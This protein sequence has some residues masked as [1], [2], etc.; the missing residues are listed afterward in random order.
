MR[1]VIINRSDARGGAAVVSRRLMHA[2]RREGVDATM[3][4]AEKLTND[5]NVH[6]AGTSA[7]IRRAFLRER[8]GVFL[9]NGLN[10]RDLFKV[11]TG[12][13]GLPLWLH[14]LVAEADAVCLGWVNQGFLSLEGVRRIAAS[15][16]V[17]WT[18]H[19]MWCAT[20]ICHHAETCDHYVNKCG[21]CPLL[22]RMKGGKD[23][24]HRVWRHKN[25][26]YEQSNIT[27]VAVSRWLRDR[28]LNSSL[29]K[30]KRVEVIGNP[31]PIPEFRFEPRKEAG[32]IKMLMV[33]AR[34]D[35]PIKGLDTLCMAL[36][37]LRRDNEELWS[38]LHLTLIGDIKDRTVLRSLKV[39]YDAVGSVDGSVIESYYRSADLL[40]SPS[41]YETLPGTLV[42][43]QAYGTLPVAFDSGGQRDIV[44]PGVTGVLAHRHEDGQASAIEFAKAIV[45]G[46]NILSRTPEYELA[47]RMYESVAAKFSEDR[48]AGSYMRIMQRF[49]SK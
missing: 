22:H 20:G 25:S 24:S 16:P 47:R 11:D 35:D 48:V 46:V 29:L 17:V 13:A 37:V 7:A 18:M 31:F 32:K 19:D 9:C 44:E 14:P 42:E 1:V 45:A 3:L 33:A 12:D 38:Q 49:L 6:V 4:V 8:L 26:L 27:F 10:R 36:E 40:L 5:V 34:L 39:S 41:K 30:N 15:K 28:C 21:V 23:L 43:A 2:L